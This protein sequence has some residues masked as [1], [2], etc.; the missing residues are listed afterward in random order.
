MTRSVYPTR[1]SS[2]SGA[3]WFSTLLVLVI[4]GLAWALQNRAQVKTWVDDFRARYLG[5]VAAAPAG[6]VP[7][8]VVQQQVEKVNPAAAPSPLPIDEALEQ[9]AKKSS[10]SPAS[11]TPSGKTTTSVKKPANTTT[12]K[13]PAPKTTPTK[14]PTRREQAAAPTEPNFVVQVTLRDEQRRVVYEGPIDLRPTMQRVLSGQVLDRYRHDGTVFQNREGRLPGAPVGYYREWVVPT[15]GVSGPG[16][17]RLVTGIN[18]DVW[19]THDH[20]QTFQRVY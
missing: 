8:A 6:N 17:Q 1:R 9:E 14:K 2:G 20:Y 18:G 16:P 4:I 13:K 11:T 19:Y 12:A 7:P 3:R 10:D 15:P 5:P